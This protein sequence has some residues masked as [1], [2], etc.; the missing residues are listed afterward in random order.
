MAQNVAH[1]LIPDIVA[2]HSLIDN[3]RDQP[4]RQAVCALQKCD[5]KVIEE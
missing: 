4:G 3:P 5:R 2:A 1:V